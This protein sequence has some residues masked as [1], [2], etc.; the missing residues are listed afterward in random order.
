[1]RL[2]RAGKGLN[3]TYAMSVSTPEVSD[4][5]QTIGQR[6]GVVVVLALFAMTGLMGSLTFAAGVRHLL[7]DEQL[8]PVPVALLLIAVGLFLS[9]ISLGYFFFRYVKKPL[10]DA[11][12]ARLEARY[13]GQP[14]MLRK[15]WPARRVVH[16][17]L[18]LTIFLWIWTVGW[19][20]ALAFIGTVNRQKIEAVLEAS[21]WNYALLALFVLCGV[22]G[23]R[24]A[25]AATWDYW[26]FGRSVLRLDTFP[27]HHG[28]QFRGAIEA[29]LAKRPTAPLKAALICES[30]EWVTYK[31]GGKTTS[32]LN[33]KQLARV[34]REIAPSQ[35]LMSRSGARI[36]VEIDLPQ[37]CSETSLDD[38]G[39]GIRWTLSVEQLGTK[40]PFSCAF[41]IPVYARRP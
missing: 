20:G 13:P 18:G 21:W 5:P 1:M 41:E 16:S 6:I 12:R 23:L 30:L 38:E 17:N 15:D 27:A 26:R 37:A 10:W 3:G 34:E 11:E 4:S 25:I 19:W 36:P 7:S 31:S 9:A 14:W 24:L 22:A 32:K 2:R 8:L 35:I 39:N 40:P 29:R 28:D 33:V